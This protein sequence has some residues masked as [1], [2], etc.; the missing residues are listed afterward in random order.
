MTFTIIFSLAAFIVAVICKIA[1]HTADRVLS[2]IYWTMILSSSVAL[3]S[4]IFSKLPWILVTGAVIFG[5]EYMLSRIAEAIYEV[6]NMKPPFF[7]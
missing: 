3:A 1:D 6:S 4:I 5:I 7:R 2:P